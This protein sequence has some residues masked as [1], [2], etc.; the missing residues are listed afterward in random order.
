MST[1]GGGGEGREEKRNTPPV[2]CA[3]IRCD[4]RREYTAP[5]A[6]SLTIILT[7]S[8]EHTHSHLA[9]HNTVSTRSTENTYFEAF[10][11]YTA[12]S[13]KYRNVYR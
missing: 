12:R 11:V 2:Q 6:R 4:T 3:E 10:F 13:E 7:H 9:N 8:H 1:I 5:V